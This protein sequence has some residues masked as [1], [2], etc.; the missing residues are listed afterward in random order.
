MS[1][2]WTMIW[3]ESKDLIFQG[4]RAQLIRPLIVVGIMGV[5][6][7]YRTGLRWLEL[8][9]PVMLVVVL[10]P[11]QYIVSIIGDAIAGERE[12][13][14]LETLLATRIPD[15]AILLGKVIVAV[16]YAW[17][18]ALA[19]LL[20]ASVVVNLSYGNGSLAFY[21]PLEL[22]LE[23]LALSFLVSLL[24]ASAG[25][26]VSL[27]VATVRQAQQ[28][29]I[30]GTIVLILG[31]VLA[32]SLLPT[33]LYSSLSYSQILLVVIAVLAILDAVLLGLSLVSFQ[34]SRLILS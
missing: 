11:F 13:H 6:L 15:R 19:G 21:H 25:V 27:R 8:S 31:G 22:F 14:T 10:V 32:V 29:L 5:A 18:M 23:A 3:K 30:I 17:G 26:L 20:L 34:R 12:R 16:G 9:L 1:D 2:I 4:G 33:D 24:T 28:F 7:P